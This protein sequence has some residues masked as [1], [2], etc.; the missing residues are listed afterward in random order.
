VGDFHLRGSQHCGWYQ[1]SSTSYKSMNMHEETGHNCLFGK[2]M[3][4]GQ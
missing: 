2:I 3:E 4:K 1:F